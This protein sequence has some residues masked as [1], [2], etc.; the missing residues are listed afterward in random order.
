MDRRVSASVV[1]LTAVALGVWRLAVLVD[2][3]SQPAYAMPLGVIAVAATALAVIVAGAVAAV[4]RPRVDLTLVSL[5]ATL[6][7][8]YGF[9]GIF[10]IGLP[11][12][13]LGIALVAV[14]ARRY[15][16]GAPRSSMLSGPALA[17]GLVTLLLLAGQMPV[18]ACERGGVTG[19]TPIWL[20]FGSASGS[21]SSIGSSG[22][23]LHSGRVSLDG[24][25]FTYTCAGGRLVRFRRDGR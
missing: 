1:A 20:A 23:D 22:S 12:L 4:L 2:H 9:L 6:L 13:G 11:L 14:L 15:S 24:S 19:G 17:I 10:S 7:L 16:A 18:V 21:T 3:R 8:V 5:A 25:T